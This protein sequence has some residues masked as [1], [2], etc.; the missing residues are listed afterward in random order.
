MHLSWHKVAEPLGTSLVKILQLS[1]NWILLAVASYKFCQTG[2]KILYSDLRAQSFHFSYFGYLWQSYGQKFVV[3]PLLCNTSTVCCIHENCDNLTP[4][5]WDTL[6]PTWAWALR[7]VSLK[8]HLYWLLVSLS[9]LRK[10]DSVLFFLNFCAGLLLCWVASL[11][12]S[13]NIAVIL[14]LTKTSAFF[15][16]CVCWSWCLLWCYFF[17]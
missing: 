15:A 13:K 2:T 10:P 17:F 12:A 7:N 1:R 3:H 16:C 4:L 11:S 5:Y 8:M 6:W 9:A 14:C